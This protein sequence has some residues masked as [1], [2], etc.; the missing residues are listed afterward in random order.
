MN[1]H[2]TAP[3]LIVRDLSAT[4]ADQKGSLQALEDLS[5][6]IEPQQFVCVLGPSGCGKS[7]LLRILAGLLRPTAGEV[8]F[9]RAAGWAAW[10][11]AALSGVG[12]VFQNA[13]LM[14]WRTVLDN[15][16]LPLELQNIPRPRRS[17]RRRSWSRWW[18]CRDSKRRCRPTFPAG[19]R[20]GWRSPG[21]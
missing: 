13:N 21:P 16:L 20:S 4:F 17:N 12:F 14:P 8:L 19:W 5:F 18:A 7:T 10:T 6:V 15:I 9:R 11:G 3:I 2:P 1:D